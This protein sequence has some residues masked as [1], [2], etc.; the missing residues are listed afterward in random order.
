MSERQNIQSTN[1]PHKPGGRQENAAGEAAATRPVGVL[2]IALLCFFAAI[3]VVLNM[4][5]RVLEPNG[6][7]DVLTQGPLGFALSVL[8]AAFFLT[9]GIGLLQLRPW[10]RY[11]G[12]AFVGLSIVTS[13][14]DSFTRYPPRTA[15]MLSFIRSLLPIALLLYLLHPS[16]RPAFGRRPTR[17]H[18]PG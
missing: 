6:I 13:G 18:I 17:S 16:I 7:A 3:L 2:L 1:N 8:L 4:V 11:L 5:F 10:G 9:T 12:L 15:L 14:L